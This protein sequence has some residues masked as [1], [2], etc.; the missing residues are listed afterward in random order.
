[1]TIAPPNSVV[2]SAHH[3][4]PSRVQWNLMGKVVNL[5]SLMCLACLDVKLWVSGSINKSPQEY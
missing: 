5:Q 1:L 3:H 4:S 2:Q